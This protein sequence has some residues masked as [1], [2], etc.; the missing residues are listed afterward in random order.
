[1]ENK[2]ELIL[3]PKC[4]A[5]VSAHNLKKHF[6]R[7]HSPEAEREHAKKKA[8]LVAAKAAELRA[9]REAAMLLACPVCEAGVKA[10]NLAKHVRIKHG[11]V[12][13]S[14][15]AKGESE[16]S[17][18]F[19]SAREREAFF[20]ARLGPQSDEESEDAFERGRIL[21]GGAF[22]LGKSRKH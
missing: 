2:P 9:Q 6:R 18:R 3:C 13:T 15:E 4:S 16:P 8:T 14:A 19:R 21:H 1:M 17:N 10:K 12:L 20:K 22:E 5:P 11:R 7:A